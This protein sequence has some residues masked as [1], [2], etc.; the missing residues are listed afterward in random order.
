MDT[1]EFHLGDILSITSGKLVSPRHIDGV[2]DILGFMT[3]D[4]VYIHQVGRISEEC[5]PYLLEA[6]PWLNEI[7]VGDVNQ[8]NYKQWVAGLTAT[9]GTMHKVRRIHPE[10]HEVKDSLEELQEFK[11]GSNIIQIDSTDFS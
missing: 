5:K 8:H 9:Y 6:M 4:E 10:D 7:S 2:M 3:N 11:P 1:K